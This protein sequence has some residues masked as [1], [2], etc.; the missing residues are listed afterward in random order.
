MNQTVLQTMD[1]IRH[2]NTEKKHIDNKK[3]M[4]CFNCYRGEYEIVHGGTK[5]K[6]LNWRR[7]YHKWLHRG[8]NA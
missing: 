6:T 8:G 4:N 1:T 3:S 5:K 2:S 7:G